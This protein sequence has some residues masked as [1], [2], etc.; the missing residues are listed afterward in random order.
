MILA[1]YY[2]AIQK[3]EAPLFLAPKKEINN[4]HLGYSSRH[5]DKYVARFLTP[6]L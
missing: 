6:E 4:W 1:N 2:R 3:Q 5:T